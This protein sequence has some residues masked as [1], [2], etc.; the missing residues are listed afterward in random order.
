MIDPTDCQ[1]F[2]KKDDT[3]EDASIPLRRG[4]KYSV[5]A[6]GAREGESWVG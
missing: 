4:R 3:S 2:N 6:E 1:K 5:E